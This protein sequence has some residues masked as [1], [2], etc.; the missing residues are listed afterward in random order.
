[1][2]STLEPIEV[3]L[4]TKKYTKTLTFIPT[5]ETTISVLVEITGTGNYVK[6]VNPYVGTQ[7][8]IH[9]QIHYQS[10]I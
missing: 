6:Y 3:N 8:L 7:P 2:S 10:M 9:N 5:A 4:T 1:M